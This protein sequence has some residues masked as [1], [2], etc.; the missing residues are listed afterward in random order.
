MSAMFLLFII[1]AASAQCEPDPPFLSYFT[2]VQSAIA[3]LEHHASIAPP[4]SRCVSRM[5]STIK[6][7]EKPPPPFCVVLSLLSGLF[8]SLS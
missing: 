8:R 5:V 7:Y 1:A 2:V 4:A 3:L 6:I